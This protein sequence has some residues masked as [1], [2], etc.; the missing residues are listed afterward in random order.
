[1]EHQQ[2]RPCIFTS[3]DLGS[4]TDTGG[5][6]SLGGILF[7]GRRLFFNF[8]GWHVSSPTLFSCGGCVTG[9]HFGSSDWSGDGVCQGWSGAIA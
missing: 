9:H 3:T 2:G 8:D 1:M 6:A 7:Q 5:G 4:S